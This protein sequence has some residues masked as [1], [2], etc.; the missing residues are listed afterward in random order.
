[1]TKHKQYGGIPHLDCGYYLL[2]GGDIKRVIVP[3]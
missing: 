2:E 1:M 3:I